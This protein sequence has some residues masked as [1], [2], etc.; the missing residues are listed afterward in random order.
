MMACLVNLPVDSVSMTESTMIIPWTFQ[1][2][3]LGVPSPDSALTAFGQQPVDQMALGLIAQ[4]LLEL[5]KGFAFI[6]RQYHL[7]VAGSNSNG[8]RQ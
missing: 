2:S 3:A 4:F 7:E 1:A 8:G 6:G 5:G